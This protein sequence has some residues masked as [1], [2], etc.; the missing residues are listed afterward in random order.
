MPPTEYALY[1][2]TLRVAL[3]AGNDWGQALIKVRKLPE[4]HLFGWKWDEMLR[5]WVPVWK[6]KPCMSQAL[7]VL[8][9]CKCKKSCKP[10]CTCA[11]AQIKC[12]SLFTCQGESYEKVTQ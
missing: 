3:K 4:P 11:V 9:T 8:R 10:P 1:Q 7:K 2:H 6:T 12:S 5:R